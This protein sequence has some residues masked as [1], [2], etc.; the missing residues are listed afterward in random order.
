MENM[1]FSVA[2]P[3]TLFDSLGKFFM[4]VWTNP[5]ADGLQVDTNDVT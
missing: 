3:L 5:R 4:Q 2:T 1:S